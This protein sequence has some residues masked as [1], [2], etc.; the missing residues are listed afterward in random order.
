MS[1]RRGV[2]FLALDPMSGLGLKT[3][4]ETSDSGMT[5]VGRVDSIEAITKPQLEGHTS[6]S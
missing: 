5:V 6:C 3:M 1:G 2:L 4:F